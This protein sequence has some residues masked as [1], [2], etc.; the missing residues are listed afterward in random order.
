MILPCTICEQDFETDDPDG[1]Y[2]P[3]CCEE[4]AAY[5][6]SGGQTINLVEAKSIKEREDARTK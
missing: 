6:I 3:P 2:C 5:L 1:L 4:L